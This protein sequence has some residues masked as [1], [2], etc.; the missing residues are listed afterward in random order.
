MFKFLRKILLTTLFAAF[1]SQ[2]SA[3]FIQADW[4]DPSDPQVGTNRYA[5]SHNDPINWSDPYG[6]VPDN[7]ATEDN[8]VAYGSSGYVHTWNSS[9]GT[10]QVTIHNSWNDTGSSDYLDNYYKDSSTSGI[11]YGHNAGTTTFYNDGSQAASYR[12]GSVSKA[13]GTISGSTNWAEQ[14]AN[15][16]I[17]GNSYIDYDIALLAAGPIRAGLGAIDGLLGRSAATGIP[18]SL[19]AAAVPQITK[20]QARTLASKLGYTKAKSFPFNAHG[21]EVFSSGGKYITRDVGSHIG[22]AWKMFD[23]NGRRL[24]TYDIDLNWIGQ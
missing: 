18:R 7:W 8:Q 20:V 12:D 23:R 5:Y 6:N 21:Q 10:S 1:A 22:G 17:A 24:G 2:A 14:W 4:Y 16:G 9:T 13:A 3:M 15:N 19:S 11:T